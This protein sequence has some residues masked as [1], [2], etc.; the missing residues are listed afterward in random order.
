[1]QALEKRLNTDTEGACQSLQVE[2]VTLRRQLEKCRAS[3]NL[4]DQEIQLLRQFD[5]DDKYAAAPV[6]FNPDNFVKNEQFK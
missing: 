2:N 3:L 1:M 6:K 4:R 5:E